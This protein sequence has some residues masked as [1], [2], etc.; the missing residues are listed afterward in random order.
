MNT[1]AQRS[2]NSGLAIRGKAAETLLD[3]ILNPERIS[4]AAR[5]P[6]MAATAG[7]A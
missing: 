1:I 6:R 5:L 7:A 3:S 4:R 2:G